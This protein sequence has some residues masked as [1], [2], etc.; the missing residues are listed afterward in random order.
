MFDIG[1]WELVLCAVV[2]LIVLGPERL[3]SAI[4]GVMRWVYTIRS[5]ANQ[6]KEDLEKEIQLKE[7]REEVDKARQSARLI[8][9]QIK[10]S[11]DLSEKT[12]SPHSECASEDVN[13][14]PSSES[15]IATTK[16][17]DER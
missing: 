6:V 9:G 2:G 1:F 14:A 16:E 17:S 13:T 5:M 3:P 12:N 4:R 7:L 15:V 11:I 8:G 10:D